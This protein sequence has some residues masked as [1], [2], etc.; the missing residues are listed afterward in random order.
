MAPN[1]QNLTN[2]EIPDADVESRS[3]PL[4]DYRTSAAATTTVLFRDLEKEAIARIQS[5]DF[6]VGCVAWLTHPRI[7]ESLRAPRFGASIV[8]QKEDFLRPDI[9]RDRSTWKKSLRVAYD[10][11]RC[12]LDRYSVG[13]LVGDLSVCYDPTLPALRCVGNHNREKAPAFPRMHNKF[14]VFCRIRITDEQIYTVQPYPIETYSVWTGSFNFTENATNSFENAVV[15]DSEEI[16]RAYFNEWQQIVALSEPLDWTSD[17]V[18]PE[19][20]IGT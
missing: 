2:I 18:E 8:V 4:V 5:A 13:G 16:A 17:W 15:I 20:R 1:M 11:M 7:I 9:G 14:L 19:W 10:S 12:G 6:V 3:R